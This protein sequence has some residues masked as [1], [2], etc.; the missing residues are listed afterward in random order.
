MPL[1]LKLST[2][3]AKFQDFLYVPL[4]E[5]PGTRT[6][7]LALQER[8]KLIADIFVII[9]FVLVGTKVELRSFYILNPQ[10]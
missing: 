7:A 1:R 10:N 2:R 4:W 9:F 3:N 5:P 8:F 6:Q